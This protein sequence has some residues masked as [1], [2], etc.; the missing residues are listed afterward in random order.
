MEELCRQYGDLTERQ[1]SGGN[2]WEAANNF[3]W[4]GRC[5]YCCR[6]AT[7]TR[8]LGMKEQAKLKDVV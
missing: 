2:Q 5:K 4:R 3:I 7:I 1:I 6:L 8:I